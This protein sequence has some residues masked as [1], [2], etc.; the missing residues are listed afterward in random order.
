MSR[1]NVRINAGVTSLHHAGNPIEA[2][3][4]PRGFPEGPKGSQRSMDAGRASPAWNP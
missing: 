4:Q 3:S 2:G 1:C